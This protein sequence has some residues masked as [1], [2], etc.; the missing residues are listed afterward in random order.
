MTLSEELKEM[1]IALG[2][3]DKV[4]SQ[5]TGNESIDQLMEMYWRKG[6][7]F[8]VDK[9][10]PPIDFMRKNMR[11]IGLQC[12]GVYFDEEF[13]VMNPAHLALYEGANGTAFYGQYVTGDVY[14]FS[15][16]EL[17]IICNEH[18]FVYVSL[19]PGS[20]LHIAAHPSSAKIGI[21]NFGGT[22]TGDI[23]NVRIH[24]KNK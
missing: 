22:I 20:K 15:G 5:W 16:S 18:S 17:N 13:D 23:T 7:D 8:C 3:C 10:F 6:S 24:N 9:N 19:Q 11:S 14:L 2:A 12:F 4:V 21:S 1:A